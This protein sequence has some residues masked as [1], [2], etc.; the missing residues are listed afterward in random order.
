MEAEPYPRGHTRNHRQIGPSSHDLQELPLVPGGDVVGADD[1]PDAT[2]L[3]AF[4]CALRSKM[5]NIGLKKTHCNFNL[6]MLSLFIVGLHKSRSRD[7]FRDRDSRTFETSG[8][9]LRD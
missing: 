1:R 9:G 7:D 5:G 4:A 3:F 6:K 2:H 8:S